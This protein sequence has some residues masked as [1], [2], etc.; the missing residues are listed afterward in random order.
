MDMDSWEDGLEEHVLDVDLNL[1]KE[2]DDA[3]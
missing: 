2:G 3:K 1:V